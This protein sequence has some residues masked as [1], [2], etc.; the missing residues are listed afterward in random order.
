M[1]VCLWE[2]FIIFIRKGVRE[3]KEDKG[4]FKE[5]GYKWCEWFWVG[6]GYFFYF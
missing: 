6:V 3:D 1:F 5:E 4:E 2:W